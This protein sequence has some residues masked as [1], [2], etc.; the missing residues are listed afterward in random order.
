M[1][2]L[3]LFVSSLLL[4]VSVGTFLCVATLFHYYFS[5]I[6]TF[7]TALF[8]HF[9][10]FLACRPLSSVWSL[11]SHN[12][13]FLSQNPE[14]LSRLSSCRL[15]VLIMFISFCLFLIIISISFISQVWLCIPITSFLFSVFRLCMYKSEPPWDVFLLRQCWW[16]LLAV[17]K[18]Y[19]VSSL[20]AGGFWRGRHVAKRWDM[21]VWFGQRRVVRWEEGCS[22]TPCHLDI[23]I[24]G[25]R[26]RG[27]FVWWN[28]CFKN[29]TKKIQWGHKLD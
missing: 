1:S 18:R 21:A 4:C 14:F 10:F 24:S 13:D 2:L 28:W 20:L 3:A 27:V 25:R 5:I 11:L 6:L 29:G 22:W 15:S 7:S 26:P 12:S 16:C 9:N 19:L 17:F 8:C 23:F